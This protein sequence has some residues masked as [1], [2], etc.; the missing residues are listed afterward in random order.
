MLFCIPYLSGAH[1]HNIF[2]HK[3]GVSLDNLSSFLIIL[4][5]WII[6]LM[7][8]AMNQAKNSRSLFLCF[9]SLNLI[10]ILR[11][12]RNSLLG[13]Y[14]FF[15]LSL[16]PT[17]IIIL[18]WGIQPERIRAGRYLIIY[19]L[20]GSL[21]L[22]GSLLYMDHQ[23]GRSKIFMPVIKIS[24]FKSFDYR[25]FCIFWIM[26]FLVK[27]PIYG[28][29]LWL[30]KAHVEAPVGGS[31][32]LAGVL[33]KLGA[34]GLIRRIHYIRISWCYWRKLLFIWSIFTMCLV[35]LMCFRQCDLKSLVAYSSVAHMSLILAACFSC[36]IIGVKGVM[37]MLISHGLCSSGLFFGVQCLYEKRG[38]RRIYLNRGIISLSPIFC[39][40]WFIFCVGNASAPPRLNLL[41]EFFLI[42][43]IINYGGIIRGILCGI[44]IFLGGLFRIYLYVLVCHGKWSLRNK[45]WQP[46]NFRKLLILFLHAVPLY[47]LIFLRKNIFYII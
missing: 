45:F 30:P 10:L 6:L 46:T 12:M 26:A 29:H 24:F 16:I 38:S 31:M 8:L 42:S 32:I 34:Y 11:F 33:L 19:T 1:S 17:L 15:E 36:D 5:V 14:I 4:T 41:R 25:I 13:F 18:G 21:P 3:Y 47:G 40:F 27:L 9:T 43:S 39:F 28:L 7:C 37:R 20:V 35:G 44:S 2:F 23:C 22:L